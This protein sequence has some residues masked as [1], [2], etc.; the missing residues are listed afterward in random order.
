MRE[1]LHRLKPLL[2]NPFGRRALEP[3]MQAGM[4]DHIGRATR[5]LIQRG[6][7]VKDTPDIPIAER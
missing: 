4:R 5:R 2:R 6:M 1:P 7:F 3:E